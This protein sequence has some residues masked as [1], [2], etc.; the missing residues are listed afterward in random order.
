MRFPK[1][2]NHMTLVL[3]FLILF[4]D[5][6]SF[7]GILFHPKTGSVDLAWS[8]TVYRRVPRMHLNKK[9]EAERILNIFYSCI[10]FVKHL[11]V[12][13]IRVWNKEYCF[14]FCFCLY[15]RMFLLSLQFKSICGF[16]FE[17]VSLFIC[18]NVY[19]CKHANRQNKYQTN[20]WVRNKLQK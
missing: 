8:A 19:H 1:R 13:E 15:F 2:M 3:V 6:C 20:N 10:I 7:F 5:C 9:E 14:W 4:I 17:I 12:T 18:I 11:C 16:S